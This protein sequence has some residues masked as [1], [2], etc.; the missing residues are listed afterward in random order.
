MQSNTGAHA[1][2]GCQWAGEGPGDMNLHGQG[3]C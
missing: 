2:F 3:F 1:V